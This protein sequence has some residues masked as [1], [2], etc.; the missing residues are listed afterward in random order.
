MYTCIIYIYIICIYIYICII[1]II[2][3]I[4][5]GCFSHG[6]QQWKGGKVAQWRCPVTRL[7]RFAQSQIE[8]DW[9]S[10]C[11]SISTTSKKNNTPTM[12]KKQPWK[13]MK[14]VNTEVD[15]RTLSGVRQERSAWRAT[16]H[17]MPRVVGSCLQR[18]SIAAKP[19]L[20]A[21]GWR[22]QS[23]KIWMCWFNM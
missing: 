13:C 14:G 21:R 8:D 2:I 23:L 5:T 10:G 17:K 4:Y 6:S 7:T 19:D 22:S 20:P 1:N 9:R 12:R 11:R 16:R 18:S 15:Q 3:Y